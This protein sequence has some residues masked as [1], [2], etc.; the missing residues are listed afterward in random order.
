MDIN[1]VARID[2]VLPQTQCTQCG[3]PDCKG[4]AEAIATGEAAIDQCPP[5]DADGI[6]ELARITGR[7]IIPLNPTFGQPKPFALAYIDEAHCIGCTL[8]IQACP[9]DAILGAVKMMHTVLNDDCTGCE[10]CIAPCPVDCIEMVPAARPDSADQRSAQSSRWREK[11]EQRQ[12]RRDR[13]LQERQDRL[14]QKALAKLD[15]PHFGSDE[16]QQKIANALIRSTSRA[17]TATDSTLAASDARRSKL[18]QI[19][20]RAAARLS[21]PDSKEPR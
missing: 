5:G 1:L 7:P 20:A 15:D 12:Q 18:E 2:A 8:C 6:A 9:T 4:Y 14:A 3:Y 13:N 10:L 19:M 11:R 17:L 16:T 21:P